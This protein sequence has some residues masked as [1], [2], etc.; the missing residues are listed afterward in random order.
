MV[1]Q[2]N[3]HPGGHKFFTPYVLHQTQGVSHSPGFYIVWLNYIGN[4]HK[5]LFFLNNLLAFAPP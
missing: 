4:L 5:R 2:L 1:N 3:S